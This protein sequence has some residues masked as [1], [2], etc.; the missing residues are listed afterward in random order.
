MRKPSAELVKHLDNGTLKKVQKES[1]MPAV[2][3][4]R[5]VVEAIDLSDLE[6]QK[7]QE[8]NLMCK[9]IKNIIQGKLVEA[10]MKTNIA[11][12]E[13]MA[14]KCFIDNETL[15]KR[16]ERHGGEH[17]VIVLP[18]SLTQKLIREVHGNVMC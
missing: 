1:E 4:S 16:I 12:I 14:K 18:S 9:A 17:T 5:N 11:N 7:E 15:W 6:L 2:F 13:K 3:L 10:N 8:A